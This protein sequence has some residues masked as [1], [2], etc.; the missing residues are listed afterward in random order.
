MVEATEGSPLAVGVPEQ[1]VRNQGAPAHGSGKDKSQ[2]GPRPRKSKGG[3]AVRETHL[4]KDP[5]LFA[6]EMQ[7]KDTTRS[8]KYACTTYNDTM[9]TADG[10]KH[11]DLHQVPLDQLPNKLAEFFM[12][13]TKSDGKTL[14]N[15]SSLGTIYQSLARFFSEEAAVKVDI[16]A[17]HR[18]KVV[19]TN[20]KA[21]QKASC[22]E[23]QVPGKMRAEA[24]QDQHLALCWEKKTL[25]RDNPDAISATAHGICIMLLGFRAKSE[26]YNLRNEDFVFG[27]TGKHGVP[28]KVEVSERITKTRQGEL[29][30][31]RNVRPVVYPDHENPDVCPVRTLVA[32]QSRKTEAQRAPKIRFFLGVKQSARRNP[33]Q[34]RFWFSFKPLGINQVAKL[35][36]SAFRAAGIDTAKEHITGT[37][38]RK[39]AMEGGQKHLVPNNMLSGL[40]GHSNAN[41]LTSYIHG[42]ENSH[43]ALSLIVTR[44]LGQKKTGNFGQVLA[45]VEDSHQAGVSGDTEQGKLPGV[46]VDSPSVVMQPSKPAVPVPSTTISDLPPI[47][48]QPLTPAVSVPPTT[49]SALTP[50]SLRPGLISHTQPPLQ[51]M[52]TPPLLSFPGYQHPLLLPQFGLPNPLMLMSPQQQFMHPSI[53]FLGNPVPNPTS[54]FSCQPVTYG[55][56]QPQLDDRIQQLETKLA[57]QGK[58]MDKQRQEIEAKDRAFA[59]HLQRLEAE[60]ALREDERLGFLNV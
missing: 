22:K 6:L 24:F 1:A 14:L 17:D 33:M 58:L 3:R 41:S 25:G 53:N 29:H 2:V 20:L 12:L 34:E 44:K 11:I 43:E 18:F 42:K 38:G 36:S 7:S 49:I 54:P 55:A 15:A 21:A 40:A 23:G 51:H 28:T 35:M 19:K 13:V 5:T 59:D 4:N 39:A 37:S 32:F 47:S 45:E 8:T 30:G 57:E 48:M 60:G 56:Q 27:A 10:D 9:R 16:K 31:I 52:A 50:I 26:C 46:Q